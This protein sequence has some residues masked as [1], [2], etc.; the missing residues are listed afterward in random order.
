[1]I[2]MLI[3]F[4][5][6][7]VVFIILMVNSYR[8]YGLDVADSMLSI[9]MS[10]CSFIGLLILTFLFTLGAEQEFVF[11]DKTPIFA[12]EYSSELSGSF[13][14][15]SGSFSSKNEYYYIGEYKGGK[16]IYNTPQDLSYVLE[17]NN[18]SPSVE[19]QRTEFK[20]SWLQKNIP[21]MHT[22]TEYKFTIPKNSIK[23]D[24]NID[25]KSVGE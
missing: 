10:F 25:L 22:K 17:D 8:S 13:F 2:T 15:G 19:I 23:Y 4:G 16:K 12:I 24:Y 11:I 18:K 6:P 9:L 7:V 5:I 21:N 20:N 3:Y 1:M 14:L